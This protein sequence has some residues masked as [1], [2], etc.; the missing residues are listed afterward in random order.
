MAEHQ[1]DL[2][3]T[4]TVGPRFR[5]NDYIPS[6]TE[7]P[8]LMEILRGDMEEVRKCDEEIAELEERLRVL[9]IR[10]Q[11]LEDDVGT[12]RSALSGHRRIPIELW[13]AIFSL[14][15]HPYAFRI[16][17]DADL[18][19][20]DS[21]LVVETPA[22]ALSQVCSRWRKIMRGS[23]SLWC[24]VSVL[25]TDLPFDT[26]K[27]L[28]THFTNAR[29]CLLE[30]R[31]VRL[32]YRPSTQRESELSTWRML[33]QHLPLC[34]R[35]SLKLLSQADLLVHEGIS[36]PHLA[37]LRE[38]VSPDTREY[39][40]WRDIKHRAPLLTSVA[41]W[42]VHSLLPFSQLRS[43][44]LRTLPHP[45]LRIAHRALCACTS[46]EE[47]TLRGLDDDGWPPTFLNP[48]QFPES[49]R[50]LCI[51]DD[52]YPIMPDN[53]V[54]ATFLHMATIPSLI[55]FELQCDDW[56]PLLSLLA[57]RSPLIER[58]ILTIRS[59]SSMTS[60]SHPLF[61]FLQALSSL[62]YVEVHTGI[63]DSFSSLPDDNGDHPPVRLGDAFLRGVL[64]GLELEHSFPKLEFLSLRLSDLTLDSD[65]VESVLEAVLT[66]H[67]MPSVTVLKEFRLFRDSALVRDA[68]EDPGAKFVLA[69]ALADRIRQFG[70]DPG[71]RVVIEDATFDSPSV[72]G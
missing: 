38:E 32:E 42:D 60:T 27:A 17:C 14:A 30:I 12:C 11:M 40:F 58:V 25:I 4:R 19:G 43:L 13:E 3:T 1:D 53:Q 47:L 39:E 24:S 70:R 36:F 63:S 18:P 64:S 51:Y 15:C 9:Q 16:D 72:R 52:E 45:D 21:N 41:L 28:R 6:D 2:N 62:K 50:N 66:R 69:P 55:S 33:S 22:L 5:H 29:D 54:L 56:P 23:P 31:V 65:V 35:L 68:I 34:R 49:L 8:Q 61:A 20:N 48:I 59:P 71:I 44:D 26:S 10:K 57:E 37:F 67:L 7:R 46:L